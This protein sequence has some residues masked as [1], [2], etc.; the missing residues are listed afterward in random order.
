[1]KKGFVV[2]VRSDIEKKLLQN[3]VFRGSSIVALQQF[4]IKEALDP[5]FKNTP[6]YFN[7]QEVFDEVIQFYS[8]ATN[9]YNALEFAIRG[10]HRPTVY[11]IAKKSIDYYQVNGFDDTALET[12]K[13]AVKFFEREKAYFKAVEIAAIVDVKWAEK[14][15]NKGIRFHERNSLRSH[16]DAI[17]SLLREIKYPITDK[18]DLI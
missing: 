18:E 10:G 7:F 9:H 16:A 4:D 12:A 15:G 2:K 8:N 11:K 13:I 5:D 1:M 6:I 17:R 14:I 3:P